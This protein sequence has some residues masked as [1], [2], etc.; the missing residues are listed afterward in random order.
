MAKNFTVI[1]IGGYIAPRHLKAIKETGNHLISSYDRN[2]SVGIVDSH[3]PDADFFTEFER[4]E[5]FNEKQIREGNKIDYV[6]IM[7]PNYL[8]FPHMNYALKIGADAICEKPLVLN[9]NEIDTLIELEKVYNKKVY[10]ILQLR[11]HQI[12]IDLKNKIDNRKSDSKIDI[13]LTY[14][15]SRGKWYF[16][17]WKG[18]VRKSGGLATNIGIHFFDMLTWIF[19]KL[20]SNEVHLNEPAKCAGYMELEKARV[21]WFL[22]VDYNDVPESQKK[23]GQRTYRSILID[24]E[25]LE[26]SEG[27]TDL[28]T[29]SYKEILEGRGY[30]LKDA[31]ESIVIASQIRNLPITKTSNKHRFVK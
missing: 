15:T 27:F 16:E 8:H 6:S 19:G 13:D 25:E 24:N 29:V 1:G 31:R 4:Y 28:H 14:I 2:D 23:K 11:H 22:S 5:S 30:G 12:I 3:F 21:K 26:F 17:S 9:P 20:E 10:T 18:D 7:T